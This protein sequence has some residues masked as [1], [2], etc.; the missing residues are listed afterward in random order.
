MTSEMVKRN[1]IGLTKKISKMGLPDS[2][3]PGIKENLQKEEGNFFHAYTKVMVDKL[4]LDVSLGFQRPDTKGLYDLDIMRV[5]A[6]RNKN[7][8]AESSIFLLLPQNEVNIREAYNLMQG[9]PVYRLAGDPTKESYWLNL[10]PIRHENRI[11]VPE[12]KMSQLVVETSLNS[13]PLGNVLTEEQK[14]DAAQSL[15]E[16]NRYPLRLRLTHNGQTDQVYLEANPEQNRIDVR[17]NRKELIHDFTR[18]HERAKGLS[19]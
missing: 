1:M 14:K 6:Y 10:T 19:R 17:N 11:V 12:P 4:P 15:K 9:R 8:P 7:I 2:L 5:T 13:P 3:L 16:G 18:I